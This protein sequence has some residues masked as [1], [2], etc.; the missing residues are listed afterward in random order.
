MW[1]D[2]GMQTATPTSWLQQPAFADNA[3]YRRELDRRNR[4]EFPGRPSDAQEHLI[5]RLL[6]SVDEREATLALTTGMFAARLATR[7][8]SSER[9]DALFLFSAGQLTAADA[10]QLRLGP[11]SAFAPI[12]A[13]ARTAPTTSGATVQIVAL[14]RAFATLLHAGKPTTPRA[15]LNAL[16]ESGMWSKRYLAALELSLKRPG[17]PLVTR[18][19][20][21][22]IGLVAA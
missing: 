14:A 21:R 17:G 1:H 13:A 6:E 12:V 9:P 19:A 3:T 22:D 5:D 2:R 7:L 4:G 18:T 15:A 10:D 8:P 20:R 11:L 16:R